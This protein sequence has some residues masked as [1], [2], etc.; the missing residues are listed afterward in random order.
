M[1]GKRCR[2]ADGDRWTFAVH[3]AASPSRWRKLAFRRRLARLRAARVRHGRYN[4]IVTTYEQAPDSDVI[5]DLAF[6]VG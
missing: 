5:G 1:R 2:S 3:P 6:H 4:G